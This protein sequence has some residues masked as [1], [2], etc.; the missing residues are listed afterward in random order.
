MHEIIHGKQTYKI[1]KFFEQ[2]LHFANKLR[3]IPIPANQ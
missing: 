2:T 3:N 1:S